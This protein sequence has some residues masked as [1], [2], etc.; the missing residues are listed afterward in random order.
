MKIK[1]TFQPDQID[2]KQKFNPQQLQI[3]E[4][5]KDCTSEE[6]RVFEKEEILAGLKAGIITRQSPWLIFK[7]YQPT[8]VEVGILTL[9]K[10]KKVKVE[11]KTEVVKNGSGI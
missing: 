8:F 7:F 3:L 11:K 10:I 4:V 1:Y 2:P 9:N 6:D 5:L